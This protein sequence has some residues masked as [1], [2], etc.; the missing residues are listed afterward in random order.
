MAIN[1]DRNAFDKLLEQQNSGTNRY[2]RA[3]YEAIDTI[4][5]QETLEDLPLAQPQLNWEFYK[6]NPD[7]NNWDTY[8]QLYNRAGEGSV[9]SLILQK[10]SEQTRFPRDKKLEL[11]HELLSGTPSLKVLSRT[12]KI[13]DSESHLGLN[14]LGTPRYL[15][16]VNHQWSQLSISNY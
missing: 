3:I 13:V 14:I 15:E 12:C 16:W 2:V 4:I 5:T 6:F 9:Q 11:Y 10:L 1:D 8:I 7:T